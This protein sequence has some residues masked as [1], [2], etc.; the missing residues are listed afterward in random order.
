MCNKCVVLMPLS[1]YKNGLYRHV[2]NFELA[3]PKLFED[4]SVQDGL[5]I[6]SLK[7]D[8]IDNFTMQPNND[9]FSNSLLFKSLDQSLIS[10]YIYNWKN[11]KGLAMNRMDSKSSKIPASLN[12]EL[13]FVDSGRCVAKHKGA[14][15]HPKT[16]FGYKYNVTK[17]NITDDFPHCAGVIHFN[18]K[19]AKDNYC[20]Y[21]YNWDNNKWDCLESLAMSGLRASSVSSDYFFWIPQIDWTNIHISQKELWDKGLYDE[22]VLSEMD[23]KFDESGAIV[24]C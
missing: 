4:A 6:T 20:K 3:N 9:N 22:A 10:F 16:K 7:K 17:V 1:Q 14:G 19:Q 2:E 24:K 8:K 23:L 13:D 5:C 21:A 18:T 12:I 11:N 15:Y